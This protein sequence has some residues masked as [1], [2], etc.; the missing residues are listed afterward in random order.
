MLGYCWSIVFDA[1]PTL[2]QHW[3]NLSCLLGVY[4][5]NVVSPPET[6][7]SPNVGLMMVRRRVNINPALGQRLVF[8]RT[9]KLLQQTGVEPMLL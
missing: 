2:P 1:G 3:A 7:R 8:A 5:C 9:A 6:R 4:H